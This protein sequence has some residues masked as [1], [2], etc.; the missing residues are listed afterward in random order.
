MYAVMKQKVFGDKKEV[1]AKDLKEFDEEYTNS[2]DSIV[3]T[4]TA[5]KTNFTKGTEKIEELL[6]Q[7]QDPIE[8]LQLAEC[9]AFTP[10]G[11]Q[12]KVELPNPKAQ[13][14]SVKK[15]G[16]WKP[17]AMPGASAKKMVSI[18]KQELLQK[19][20][21]LSLNTTLYKAKKIDEAQ[22]TG[23][24]DSIEQAEEDSIYIK[25]DAQEDLITNDSTN[26]ST[27]NK[28]PAKWSATPKESAKVPNR[29]PYYVIKEISLPKHPKKAPI[30][31]EYEEKSEYEYSDEQSEGQSEESGEYSDD[32]ENTEESGTEQDED[33]ETP[34]ESEAEESESCESDE[35]NVE[36]KVKGKNVGRGKEEASSGK[37]REVKN[38]RDSLEN[39]GEKA[40]SIKT[41]KI[42]NALD[43]ARMQWAEVDERSDFERSLIPYTVETGSKASGSVYESDDQSGPDIDEINIK[44]VDFLG[45][46]GEGRVYLAEIL[47]LNERVALK[48]FEIKTDQ[49]NSKKIIRTLSDEV[50]LVKSLSHPNI[51]KYYSLRKSN[52][53]KLQ[54][55]VEYN[56]FMEYMDGGSLAENI[57]K[58]SEGLPREKVQ[59]IVRQVLSGLEYLHARNIIHR[60]LKPGNILAN[61]EFDTF[62][63]TD[64]G[65]STQVKENMTNAR[66]T[67][68]GT[69]W[70]MAPEVILDEPYSYAADIWSL[71][72]LC[73]ELLTGHKPYASFGGMQAMLQM[74]KHESPLEACDAKVR[75]TLSADA[76][77][78]LKLCWIAKPG[79]RPKVGMLLRHRFLKKNELG[80]KQVKRV[81]QKWAIIPLFD[82]N[83]DQRVSTTAYM[84]DASKEEY[85]EKPSKNL[86]YKVKNSRQKTLECGII[87]DAKRSKEPTKHNGK[88]NSP[89]HAKRVPKAIRPPRMITPKENS[90]DL[91]GNG[92]D[93]Q[94]IVANS[95]S[96]MQRK[97]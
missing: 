19:M 66:R 23:S 21:K 1:S 8:E 49:S 2:R 97:N 74:V 60:D 73:F 64:F 84:T 12:A 51:I 72:C 35:V 69:P 96:R 61:K 36:A 79:N 24:L 7:V 33:E 3:R 15:S 76:L 27:K 88:G 38:E 57:R 11:H 90:K 68:A 6:H 9:Q 87:V 20:K 55:A 59:D 16:P 95:P 29:K 41:T 32:R 10:A 46:G 5:I 40:V 22:E 52:R 13:T 4:F 78:F 82:G 37:G 71:G 63:I 58:H 89:E 85:K 26:K 86:D 92:K 80:K 14:P 75:K 44:L 67:R 53:N 34:E 54:N 17:V 28:S 25:K 43:S 39:V 65:I 93:L 62:K 94:F 45:S 18:K 81:Y 91:Q 48:Q 47:S 56:L 77:D 83:E 42:L 31:D 50:E 70:Y 30:E